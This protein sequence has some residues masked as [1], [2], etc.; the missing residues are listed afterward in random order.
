[1]VMMYNIVDRVVRKKETFQLE[2]S[3]LFSLSSR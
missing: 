3:V 2:T 1:M